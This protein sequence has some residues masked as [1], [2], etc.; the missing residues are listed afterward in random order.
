MTP[1]LWFLLG[2]L[3]G[4]VV[5]IIIH[6]CSTTYGCLHIDYTNPDKDVYR[7]DV[8]DLDKLSKKKRI[9]VKIDAKNHFTQK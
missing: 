7:F 6:F 3:C 9:I 4:A 8:G 2:V 5:T 1:I